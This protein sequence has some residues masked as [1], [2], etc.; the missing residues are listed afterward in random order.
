MWLS[1][2]QEQNISQNNLTVESLLN[3]VGQRINLPY[4]ILA[5]NLLTLHF[6]PL[7]IVPLKFNS[8]KD[9]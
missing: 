8:Q 3:R 6:T 7:L 1:K 9:K 5:V 2:N 4:I